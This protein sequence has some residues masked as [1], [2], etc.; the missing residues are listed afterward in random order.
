LGTKPAEYFAGA[1]GARKGVIDT[2]LAV[3]NAGAYGKQL[4]QSAHRLLVTADD[5]DAE[6]QVEDSTRGLPSS[7]D[8]PDNVGALLAAP[9]GKYPRNTI[10]TPKIV[11]DLRAKGV[12]DILVRSPLVGGPPDGGVYARDLGI[13]L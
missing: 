11:A 4:I 6:D 7:I 3:Q 5:S 10:L 1:F 9:A 12:Q 8:D 2:K 13:R